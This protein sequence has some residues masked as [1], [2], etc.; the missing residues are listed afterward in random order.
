MDTKSQ[1]R[2]K[3][4]T[5]RAFLVG[6]LQCTFLTGLGVRLGWLQLAQG[7]RY[8]TL[9]D[10]NR[11]NLKILAPSRGQIV[12]RNAV[13]LAVNDQ[14]FRV[15]II[16]E[17]TDD[18]GR[19]LSRLQKLVD[20]TQTDIKKVVSTAERQA[21]F[22]PIEVKDN[23]AWEDVA[24]IEVH[25]TDLPGLYI[26]VGEIRTYPKS[27]STAHIVG[28][29]GAVNR[30][31]LTGDPVLTLPGFRIGKTGLEKTFD[32]ALR[33]Q[34]GSAE[35]EVNV[36]GREVRELSRNAGSTGKTVRLSVDIRL[37]DYVQ[38]RLKAET[39]ATAI[40]MDALT[41]AVYALCSS[42]SFD[43]NKFT[44]GLSAETWEDLLANPGLPLN[45]K[46]VG[47]QYP[48][49]STF[50]MV[51][52]MAGLEDKLINRNNSFYCSG[53]YEYGSDRFHCWKRGGHGRMDVVQAL[54]ESCDTY[55]YEIA[56]K[57]GID[58]LAYYARMFGL[59]ER[60]GFELTE[61][62]PGLVPD[63]AW[64]RGHY[65]KSWQP[66][67]TIVASIGQGYI[68]ATPLQMSVMTARLVNGGY[69][70]KPWMTLD[71]GKKIDMGEAQ[72][73]KLNV[74]K[75][76]LDLV[77]KG[78]EHVVNHKK[79]TASEAAITQAG[80]EMAGKTGTAQV[81]RI[82]MEDRLEGR[83]NQD[84][85]WKYRHHALFV[86]YAPYDNPRYIC[87]VV[88]EHGGSGSATAAPI[89]RD[90]LLKAQQLNPAAQKIK[91]N[92]QGS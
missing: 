64:K 90:I 8:T 17:Q 52:A 87:T 82:S 72:W 54:T 57:I 11:I 88:V 38:E 61:E 78:M 31:E 91:Q 58:R 27:E 69:A 71:A 55:F 19:A 56:T 29:V 53:Y 73:P 86:G 39:S 50:K 33:G 89:A 75:S 6:A 74:R 4:F 14:N 83:Q 35:V 84:L 45:N 9:A 62:R 68:Q 7:E 66:G 10:N 85:P 21:A 30:S 80:F 42:P 3:Q 26:E 47:G 20:L 22:V 59:G 24:K 76:N 16:P 65:G 67:E 43:P 1:D 34:A 46:A 32:E 77:R 63:Q 60:L 25:L 12:D 36:L 48:P 79:G 28:Y 49:G 51:T 2:S 81:R 92:V 37:Q 13:P 40:V 70:V 44:H 41:G 15:V 18:L 23:L 5:R